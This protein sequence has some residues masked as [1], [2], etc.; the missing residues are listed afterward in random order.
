[1]KVASLVALLALAACKPD[2]SKKAAAGSDQPAS[3]PRAQS[4]RAPGARPELP[5]EAA[6]GSDTAAQDH[7]SRLDTDGDGIITPEER[8]AARAQR[9]KRMHDR[10]DAN[11]DGKLTPD[12]LAAAGSN[13]RG[14]HFTDPAALDTDHNGEI[15]ADELQTGMREWRIE[16]RPRMNVGGDP[17]AGGSGA[18]GSGAE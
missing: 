5:D 15:S 18:D 2:P 1:M 6:N 14:P 3:A 16:H 4:P 8:Q 10:Y 13:H 7:R 17:V 12:E 11:H 9:A